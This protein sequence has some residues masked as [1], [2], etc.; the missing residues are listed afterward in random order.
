MSSIKEFIGILLLMTMQCCSSLLTSNAHSISTSVKMDNERLQLLTV[1]FYSINKSKYIV[2]S[3]RL[4][5]S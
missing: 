2:I 3:K 1:E 4:A 5:L